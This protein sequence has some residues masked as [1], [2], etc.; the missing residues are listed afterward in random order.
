MQVKIAMQN[1]IQGKSGQWTDIGGMRVFVDA[2]SNKILL[3]SSLKGQDIDEVD[4]NSIQSPE[5]DPNKMQLV[6]ALMVANTVGYKRLQEYLDNLAN[7]IKLGTEPQAESEQFEKLNQFINSY[8]PIEPRMRDFLH[9][10]LM[11]NEPLIQQLVEERD[12]LLYINKII[13]D[14]I[15]LK[16]Q[17]EKNSSN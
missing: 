15:N 13:N 6:T 7:I 11:E 1:I 12:S 16:I 10:Y 4:V 17:M 2:L 14:Q 3:P 5:I 8:A 9:K